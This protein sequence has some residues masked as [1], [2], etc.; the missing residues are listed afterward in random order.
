MARK[1]LHPVLEDGRRE[2]LAAPQHPAQRREVAVIEDIRACHEREDRGHREPLGQLVRRGSARRASA[3]AG[4]RPPEQG[5]ARARVQRSVDVEGREVEMKRRMPRDPILLPEPEV[6]GAPLDEVDRVAVLDDDALRSAGRA[7]CEEDVGRVAGGALEVEW[8]ARLAPRSPAVKRGA[9]CSDSTLSS[10]VPTAT[11]AA[12]SF[13][14]STSPRSL[15]AGRATSAIRGSADSRIMRTRGRAGHVDRHVNA[16]GLKRPEHGD[17]RGGVL[18]NEEADA[19]SA[20]A[21]ALLQQ[22]RQLIAALLELGVG[23]PLVAH[24]ERD[25]ASGRRSA[26]RAPYSCSSAVTVRERAAEPARRRPRCD[27]AP[28]RQEGCRG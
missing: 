8:L 17:D 20:L 21:T 10:S 25:V 1:P 22:P 27:R 19:I 6:C 23:Q 15:A 24:P 12:G 4:W 14:A 11:S 5:G 2:H 7:R 3:A 18:R 28:P 26:W 9:K 13:P 16:V